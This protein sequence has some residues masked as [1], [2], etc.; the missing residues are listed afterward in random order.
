MLNASLLWSCAGLLFWVFKDRLRI[1]VIFVNV[2]M[3]E[4]VL[5]TNESTDYEFSAAIVVE[6]LK[7]W[8]EVLT[9]PGD[10]PGAQLA[11]EGGLPCPFLK[12][13]KIALMM[14][15]KCLDCVHPWIKYVHLCFQLKCCFK[16][17]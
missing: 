5:I 17:T 8:C 7:F 12:T 1:Y 4:I 2:D 6:L 9:M 3:C 10:V 16:T 13:E 15:K 14:E 11:G